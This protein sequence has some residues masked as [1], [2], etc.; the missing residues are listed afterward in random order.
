[1]DGNRGGVK[2]RQRSSLRG[3]TG[4]QVFSQVKDCSLICSQYQQQSRLSLRATALRRSCWEV[5]GPPCTVYRNSKHVGPDS[6]WRCYKRRRRKRYTNGHQLTAG[7]IGGEVDHPARTHRVS[8]PGHPRPDAML[9]TLAPDDL[10]RSG[11]E[12][13][14]MK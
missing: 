6:L 13:M 7:P 3:E 10:R 11:S 9:M 12:A 14:V 5:E 2:Q 8:K 1:M 4:S